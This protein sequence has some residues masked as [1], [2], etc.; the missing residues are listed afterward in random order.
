MAI[1]G[2]WIR[3]GDQAGYLARPELA[4]LAAHMKAGK[5]LRVFKAL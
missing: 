4:R 5:P 2:E 3:Y 1:K